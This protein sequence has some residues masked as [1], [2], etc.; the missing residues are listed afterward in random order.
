MHNRKFH[1]SEEI[2]HKASL[3]N[4]M[5][6]TNGSVAGLTFMITSRSFS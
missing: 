1:K 5:N 2:I 4:V 3:Y 6:A